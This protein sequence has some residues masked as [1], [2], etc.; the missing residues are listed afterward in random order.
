MGILLGVY[1]V[2][3]LKVNPS[4]LTNE[5]LFFFG[6]CSPLPMP[7]GLTVG[8]IWSAKLDRWKQRLMEVVDKLEETER[9][10]G[11]FG[12]TGLF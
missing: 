1:G 4:V 11:G 7:C 3:C 2:I 5:Y 10:E 9:G 8:E 12:S 6:R